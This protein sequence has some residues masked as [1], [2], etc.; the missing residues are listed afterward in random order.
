MKRYI[1]LLTLCVLTFVNVKAQD[2]K[3]VYLPEQGD[4]AIGF[5]AAPVLNYVGNLFNNTANNSLKNLGGQP[6]TALGIEGFN[7]E[8]ITPSVS[9]V[10]KYMVTDYLSAKV[11]FGLQLRSM[12]TNEYVGDDFAA[13]N[14]PLN[15]AKLIDTRFDS[16]KGYSLLI[17]ADY[18]TGSNR[19][20][21]VFGGGFIFG[22]NNVATEY[23]Y[24]NAL[25]SI[26]QNPTSA[27]NDLTPKGYRT[28]NKLT[29]TNRFFGFAANVGVEYFVAPKVSL[30]AEVN[31]SAYSVKSGQ[32]YVESEGF[33]A[34][35]G[36]VENRTDI[37]SPGNKSVVFGTGNIGGSLY[38]S[39][40]F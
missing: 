20:Q 38:L 40:Y 24:A 2:E 28:L 12:T 16:Q 18:R 37:V 21:G 3:K 27:W 13:V 26:N 4:I 19:I 5:D 17:G 29:A 32:T 36:V 23:Q 15:E 6:V 22:S 14:D 1:L 11:N 7:I 34:E 33:N 30:G 10:G 39:F 9:I 8:N 25:T 35:L 31:L